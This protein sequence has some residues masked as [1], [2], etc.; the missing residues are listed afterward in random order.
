MGA[1]NLWAGDRV[2]NLS[3]PWIT[4][5]SISSCGVDMQ[6]FSWN[7]FWDIHLPNLHL[8]IVCL[9]PQVLVCAQIPLLFQCPSFCH[10]IFTS[11]HSSPSFCPLLV[12]ATWHPKRNTQFEILVPAL[13]NWARLVSVPWFLP[14]KCRGYQ[15]LYFTEELCV[16]IHI[17]S[18]IY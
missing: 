11:P 2:S 8:P 10:F 12:E 9:Y 3:P 4:L 15:I 7:A 5:R 16:F 1:L 14:P 6:E 17:F 18:W 13:P